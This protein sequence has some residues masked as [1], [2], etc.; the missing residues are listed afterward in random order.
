M[1]IYFLSLL[2]FFLHF[3]FFKTEGISWVNFSVQKEIM[4]YFILP[5]YSIV[6]SWWECAAILLGWMLTSFNWNTSPLSWYVGSCFTTIL[7]AYLQASEYLFYLI[8]NKSLTVLRSVLCAKQRA[9]APD[10]WTPELA[11]KVQPG[12]FDQWVT[13]VVS[14]HTANAACPR[15]RCN[16]GVCFLIFALRSWEEQSPLCID[17]C[18]VSIYD[19]LAWMERSM[20]LT[21]CFHS[22]NMPTFPKKIMSY[23]HEGGMCFRRGG[24]HCGRQNWE[25]AQPFLSQMNVNRNFTFSA[26]TLES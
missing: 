9:Q 18:S 14:H 10:S 24:S 22:G 25:G 26:R 12:S 4:K 5:N 8:L 6:C 21:Q 2:I 15:V 13:N 17:N 23:S 11:W 20:A 1:T 7:L 3:E 19:L 16:T